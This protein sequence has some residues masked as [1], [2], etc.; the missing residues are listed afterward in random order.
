VTEVEFADNPPGMTRH[1]MCSKDIPAS[2]MR[3]LNRVIEAMKITERTP[4]EQP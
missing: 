4:R 2:T 1:L 3:K